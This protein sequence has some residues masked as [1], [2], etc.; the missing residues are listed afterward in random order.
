MGVGVTSHRTVPRPPGG[1]PACRVRGRQPARHPRSGSAHPNGI[2]PAVA[3]RDRLDTNACANA[4]TTSHA[5]R[6]SGTTPELSLLVAGHSVHGLSLRPQPIDVHLLGAG[7]PQ[8]VPRLVL[9]RQGFATCCCVEL[10]DGAATITSAGPP[11]PLHVDQQGRATLLPVKPGPPLRAFSVARFPTRRSDV[12]AAAGDSQE[13]RS[14]GKLSRS[15]AWSLP[16][17]RRR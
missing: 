14:W 11:P 9:V 12:G 13:L 2:R 6:P 15:S 3:A 1:A 8:A 10:R 16:H 17:G 4:S 5:A 7:L